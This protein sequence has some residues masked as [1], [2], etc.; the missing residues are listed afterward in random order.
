MKPP[1]LNLTP[2]EWEIVRELLSRHV[3]DHEV[4]A[5][6]SRVN[7]RAKPFSDLDLAILG[8]QP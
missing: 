7:G 1:I 3:P 2:A 8:R 5:F 6:D 4:W